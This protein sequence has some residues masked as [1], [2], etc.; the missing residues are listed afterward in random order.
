MIVLSGRRGRQA[1]LHAALAAAVC[2]ALTACGGDKEAPAPT[3]TEPPLGAPVVVSDVTTFALPLN[4]YE[5][6]SDQSAVLGAARRKL[7]ERCMARFGFTSFRLPPRTVEP[8][9]LN[10]KRYF[11]A[12]EKRAPGFGYDTPELNKQSGGE[13]G[14]EKIS[15]EEGVVLNGDEASSGGRAVPKGGCT[16]EAEGKLQEGAPAGANPMLAQQLGMQTYTRSRDDSRVRKA[17][18]DWSACM[19]EAGYNFADPKA[20]NDYGTSQVTE[21]GGSDGA[22]DKEI[23]TAVADVACKKKVNYI[24]TWATVETAY[25]KELIEKNRGALD[26]VKATIATQLRHAAEINSGTS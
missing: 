1:L 7:I 24:N 26:L 14:A 18:A 11:L 21:N 16:A 3:P 22:D 25:Q 9:G 8:F 4:A 15:D 23:A 6:T 2:A 12:D 17:S 5:V 20:A 13:P 10:E 19:K